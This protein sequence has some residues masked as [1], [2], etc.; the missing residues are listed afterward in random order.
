MPK[1]H[2]PCPPEYRRRLVELA[3][4]R[5]DRGAIVPLARWASA[6]LPTWARER[7][8]HPSVRLRAVMEMAAGRQT[9]ESARG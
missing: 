9:A 6:G 2:H 8:L 3:S 7:A 5:E 1:G 4:I